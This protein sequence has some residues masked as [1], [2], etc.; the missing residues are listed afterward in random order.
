MSVLLKHSCKEQNVKY[1]T[2]TLQIGSRTEILNAPEDVD[3]VTNDCSVKTIVELAFKR[4]IK[5]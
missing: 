3:Q 1:F 4:V 5:H 2:G